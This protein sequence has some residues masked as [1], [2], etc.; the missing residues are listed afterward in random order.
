MTHVILWLTDSLA[1]MG[2]VQ[3]DV[4]DDAS[5]ASEKIVKPE[6][7]HVEGFKPTPMQRSF[8][9]GSTPEHLSSRFMVG[10]YV[11]GESFQD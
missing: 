6:I 3:S 8:Q 5:V 4:E 1:D 10:I 2:K 9:P 11:M 7:V